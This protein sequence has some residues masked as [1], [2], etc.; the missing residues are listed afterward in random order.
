MKT[1]I[2]HI[3][4]H[5]TGSSTIQNYLQVNRNKFSPKYVYANM[6]PSNHSGPFSFAFRDK[7]ELDPEISRMGL[8]FDTI[9]KNKDLYKAAAERALQ[10]KFEKLIL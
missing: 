9:Y 7:P 4:M 8:E 3:G 5:K 2:L 6:G 1:V 10:K